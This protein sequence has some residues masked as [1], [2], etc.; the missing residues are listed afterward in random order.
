MN[1]T[2]FPLPPD[3]AQDILHGYLR[4]TCD[5]YIQERT[6][7]YKRKNNI[8]AL[9]AQA[10]KD[11]LNSKLQKLTINF[12]N[13]LFRYRTKA[14]YRDFSFL[15]YKYT[16]ST[17]KTNNT[18]DIEFYNWLAT[19]I[20]FTVSTATVHARYRLGKSIT[21]QYLQDIT[22]KIRDGIGSSGD[23]WNQVY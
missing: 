17:N 1:H 16:D 11:P 5:Y 4:G 20:E 10:V 21:D 15:S 7:D 22:G 18:I 3:E 14:H 6:K 12:M 2:V 23:Y 8:T 13:C 19:I 9:R